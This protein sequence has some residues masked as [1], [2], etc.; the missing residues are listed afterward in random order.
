MAESISRPP[1]DPFWNYL[2]FFASLRPYVWMKPRGERLYECV[3]LAGHPALTTSNSDEPRGSFH[4]RD[5]FSPHPTI[6]G[7]WKYVTRLDDRITLVNG[8]KVWPLPMEG[9]INQHPWVGEAVVVGIGKALPG[10]LI[11]RAKEAPS[12]RLPDAEFLE[13][14]WPRIAEANA[15]AEAFSQISRDMVAILPHDAEL[16][17]TDKG[18]II[19]AQIY[20]THAERIEHLF[21]RDAIPHGGYRLDLAATETCLLRLCRDTL[22]IP[23]S[24]A[25]ANMYFEGVDSLK[26]IQL[27]RLILKQFRFDRHQLPSGNVVWESGSIS[28]LA[29]T[30]CSLQGGQGSSARDNG[31]S[32]MAEWIEKYSRFGK[33]LPHREVV[34]GSKNVVCEGDRVSRGMR[35]TVHSF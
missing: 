26:S 23:V 32:V 1:G 19:R 25:A 33:H 8:E 7:R 14:I 12:A 5:V 24:S 15:Q 30:I 3:Y 10:L 21:A 28:Q 29:Q 35:L 2:R 18:S 27:R 9:H 16:P 22:G 20:R 4:S 11:W 17:R 31:T 34:P 6:P 13:T